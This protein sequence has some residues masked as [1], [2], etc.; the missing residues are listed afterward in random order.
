[1][2]DIQKLGLI[3]GGLIGGSLA[4]ALKRAWP[5]LRVSLFDVSNEHREA[6]LS[7]GL[8]D[9]VH[10]EL[11][12]VVEGAD[13]LVMAT[14][15]QAILDLL[16]QVARHLSAHAVVTDVGSTKGSILAAARRL[17][18]Q[19][20]QNFVPGHPIAGAEKSGPQ[21]ARADLFQGR[22]VVLTPAADTAVEAIERVR[23]MWQVAGAEV[24]EL[25]PNAH[26]E[27][28]AA[29]SHLPHLLSYALVDLLACRANA[30]T[31]FSYAAGGFRDFTRIAASN[32]AVWR[33][34]TLANRE[35]I[36]RELQA[37]RDHLAALQALIESHAKDDLY[38]LFERAQRARLHSAQQLDQ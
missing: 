27:I 9:E 16:P 12:A 22:R 10:G 13:V 4:L 23:S 25:S 31:L 19:N 8:V 30:D 14:P 20:V 18:G 34:I 15:V 17:L 5:T 2:A 36:L 6:A 28:F 37:Y 32:P 21:A 7:L 33:D 29:V 11:K 1:M 26:D 38:A 3:G 24:F 35:A